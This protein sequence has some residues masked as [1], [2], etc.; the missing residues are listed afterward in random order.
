VILQL[1]PCLSLEVFTQRNF[2]ADVIRFKLNF[3]FKN[4]NFLFEPP[5]GGLGGNVHSPST[6][7][8]KARGRLPIRHNWTWF[9]ISYGR[10]VIAEICRSRRFSKGVS[11]SERKFQTEWS[12][13]RQPLKKA[14]MIALS[15]GIK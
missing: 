11:H 7:R 2:V 1:C 6:A 10:D 8:W 3:I 13:A 12:I 9:A 4:Q 14:R 15:C 5:F